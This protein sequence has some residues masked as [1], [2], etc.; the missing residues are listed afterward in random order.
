M[1]GQ[2]V[3]QVD[4]F[5][6]LG[7]IIDNGPNF[8]SIVDYVYNKQTRQRLS[9]LRSLRG[10]NTSKHTLIMVYRSLIESVLSFSIVSWYGNLSVKQRN[11]PAQV[12]NQA[13]K[14]IGDKRLSLPK[15]YIRSIT[16]KA[17]QVY[18]DPTHRLRSSFRLLP[19]GRRLKVPLARKNGY[20]KSLYWFFFFSTNTLFGV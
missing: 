13:S 16:N 6:Y 9:L 12:V 1:K 2:E 5:K 15:F 3:E 4:H 8:Q 7:T 11:K 10:F 20:K 17:T 19:S 14:I 18:K